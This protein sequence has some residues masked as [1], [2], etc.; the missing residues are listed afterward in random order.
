MMASGFSEDDRWP[1]PC[2]G[3]GAGEG[4]EGRMTEA[5]AIL[6]ALLLF[7][8]EVARLCAAKTPEVRVFVGVQA[9]PS[10]EADAYAWTKCVPESHVFVTQVAAK[11]LTLE[12][13][14]IRWAAAHEVCHLL[15]HRDL[16]CSAADTPD[17]VIPSASRRSMETEAD[18]CAFAL[19]ASAAQQPP[20]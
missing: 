9:G 11:T 6:A 18:Y 8:S 19:L 10:D 16:L 5:E 15:L 7:N 1:V 17:A 3:Y 20:E 13:E 14:K 2:F 12:P 4:L